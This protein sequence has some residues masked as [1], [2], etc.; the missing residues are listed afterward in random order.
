M[1]FTLSFTFPATSAWIA[2]L[3]A[4]ISCSTPPNS[5]APRT[6]AY[7]RSSTLFL[8]PRIINNTL[9]QVKSVLLYSIIIPYK[10]SSE[11]FQSKGDSNVCKWVT[12]NAATWP[13]QISRVMVC[14]NTNECISGFMMVLVNY[15]MNLTFE[16]CH[17]AHLK[18]WLMSGLPQMGQGRLMECV[19]LP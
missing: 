6:S 10:L 17:P 2:R 13:H 4:F 18:L 1:A 12:T 16:L 7:L 5:C 3:I 11:L 9:F 8:L 19:A 15:I 14:F